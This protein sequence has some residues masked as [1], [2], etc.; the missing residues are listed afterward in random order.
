MNLA[1]EVPP[2][3]ESLGFIFVI[4]FIIFLAIKTVFSGFV[5]KASPFAM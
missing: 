4:L 2:V 3:V 5:K 1:S